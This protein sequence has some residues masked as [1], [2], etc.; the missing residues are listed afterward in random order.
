MKI[1]K[2]TQQNSLLLFTFSCIF[3]LSLYF[4]DAKGQAFDKG[5]KVISAGVG[6]G[7]S[8]GSFSHNSQTPAL[9]VQ[10]EQGVW[11]AGED[12]VISLG[13]YAGYKSFGWDTETS[14][15][16]S[17]ASWKYTIIGLRSAYHYQG[18]DNEDLDVYAG[19][20]LAANLLNYT[21][22]DSQ[23]NRQGSG[24]FGNSTGLTI[25]L[26]GRYYFSPMA[27]GFAEIGYGI[28]YLNLGL[29]LRFQ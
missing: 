1:K 12:G 27:A 3:L 17:S 15:F 13:G 22:T 9:S 20:M 11:D 19:L 21:Y 24:N 7:S 16:N 10:Y 4:S 8:L 2:F 14:G 18:L 5:T 6:I 23:G 29:A 26:G 25:Y 28:S